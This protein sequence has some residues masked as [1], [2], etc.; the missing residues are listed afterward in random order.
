MF[1]AVLPG[2]GLSPSIAPN[3]PSR[4]RLIRSIR[5]TLRL[6]SFHWKDGAPRSLGVPA[7]PLA[8]LCAEPGVLPGDG[9]G[10]VGATV[11]D[12]GTAAVAHLDGLVTV[13]GE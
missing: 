4:N 8:Q 11:N 12:I 6:C 13:E 7:P 10:P 2:G 9:E 1:V 5:H 3:P